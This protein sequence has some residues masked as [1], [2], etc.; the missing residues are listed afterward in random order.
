MSKY[1]VRYVV[2]GTVAV[3]AATEQQAKDKVHA[4]AAEMAGAIHST[5]IV[6]P[7]EFLS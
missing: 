6:Q 2:E 7:M 3:E 4:F 5:I 1:I